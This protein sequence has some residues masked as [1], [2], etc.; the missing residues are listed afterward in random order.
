VSP[1]ALVLGLLSAVR[2]VPLAIVYALLLT[3]QPRRLLLIYLGAGVVVTL[4]VGIVVVT[5]LHTGAP[6]SEAAAG[7]LVV[8]L[9]LG[10]VGVVWAGLRLSGREPRRRRPER[11]RV[12]TRSTVLPD[13]LDRRLRAPTVPT[14]A[15]AGVVT[16]LPGLYYL[17]A[18]VAILQTQPSAVG[19]IVQVVVYTV[20]RFAAPAAAL[21][22]VVVRPDR[23]LEIVRTVHAWGRRHA[24]VLVA[25]LV[26][27]VGIYLAVK[28]ASGLFG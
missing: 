12:R 20:L 6:T 13:A 4:A 2:G 25:L 18:L 5:W 15:A 14:V 10:I 23:T 19:G 9:V 16:N 21:A 26:G 1:E 28:G 8:D 27:G 24:R 17:A 7:R 22:L 3:D 11:A